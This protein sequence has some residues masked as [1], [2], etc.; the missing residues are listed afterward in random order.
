MHSVV[1]RVN[2]VCLNQ[3]I[4]SK[5]QIRYFCNQN[6]LLVFYLF[7]SDIELSLLNIEYKCDMK[8]DAF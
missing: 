6:V 8:T 1:I 5:L 3:T 4:V 7:D 2:M